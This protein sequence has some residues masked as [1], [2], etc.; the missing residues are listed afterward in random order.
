M[1]LSLGLKQVMALSVVLGIGGLSWAQ[2]S[3]PV[4]PTPTVSPASTPVPAPAAKKAKAAPQVVTTSSGLQYR[5]L[6]EGHGDVTAKVGQTIWVHYTG[7][8]TD[9][10]KFDSSVDRN[11]PFKFILGVGQVIPGWDEGVEGMKVGEKRK[12]TIP[13]NL[14][15]GDKGMPPVIPP[16]ATLVFDVELVGVE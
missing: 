12:L 9:G 13:S 7:W 4:A 14:G 5:I 15:Y 6:K 2:D 10:T 16:K 11:E 3:T 1:R 8:L